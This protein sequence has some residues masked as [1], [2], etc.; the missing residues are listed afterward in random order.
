MNWKYG[1]VPICN[2]SLNVQLAENELKALQ[3]YFIYSAVVLLAL[4]SKFAIEYIVYIY[5]VY[6]YITSFVIEYMYC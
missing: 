6:E 1:T 5:F 3:K 2:Y 4:Y